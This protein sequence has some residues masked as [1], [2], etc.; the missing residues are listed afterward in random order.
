[1]V[2][3]RTG[4]DERDQLQDE[5][6]DGLNITSGDDDEDEGEAEDLF[7]EGQMCDVCQGEDGRVGLDP[8]C[9]GTYPDAGDPTLF[10]FNCL[11][12]GLKDAYAKLEGVA[13][14]VE[15]FGDFTAHYYYRLDEMPAYQFVREDTE[16]MSWLMLTIGDACARCGEQSHVAWLT[17]EFVD[18][19]LPEN[20][21]VFKNL[22][23]EIEH[24]CAA[25]AATALASAYR[26]LG[27]RL[28]TAELPQ[29]AMGVLMPTGD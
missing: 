15:P 4:E 6:Q 21:A 22:D 17:R 10:G 3:R 9:R 13:A 20:R 11:E 2:F 7:A 25:C 16:A 27:L 12:Q 14:I 1:M 23:G 24:L 26:D 18:E 5:D 19:R 28:M 29:S 8:T